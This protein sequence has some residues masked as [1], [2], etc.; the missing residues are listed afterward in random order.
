MDLVD[1]LIHRIWWQGNDCYD[2][3]FFEA[4][5]ELLGRVA[6]IP[7][8]D[9]STLVHL[10]LCRVGGAVIGVGTIDDVA[11]AVGGFVGL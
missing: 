6:W 3:A 8:R 11:R 10:L 2:V 4:I 1:H 7:P 5:K 9:L